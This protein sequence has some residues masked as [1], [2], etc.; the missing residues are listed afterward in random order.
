MM[1]G[2]VNIIEVKV[3]SEPMRA[4]IGSIGPEKV[5]CGSQRY[6]SSQST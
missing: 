1:I 4:P 3:V 2:S 6:S 5:V